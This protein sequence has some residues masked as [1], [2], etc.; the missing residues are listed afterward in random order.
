[1][2]FYFWSFWFFF[3]SF[4]H[5]PI[6]DSPVCARHF[7]GEVW[8]HNRRLLQKGKL[9]KHVCLSR[10]QTNFCTSVC[11]PRIQMQ[12]LYIG[13]NMHVLAWQCCIELQA[14]CIWAWLGAW[15][16]DT[17]RNKAA[18]RWTGERV[19][20]QLH[21]YLLPGWFMVTVVVV[22]SKD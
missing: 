5:L 14:L 7:C 21:L 15:L 2:F 17:H 11:C 6:S 12:K 20:S 9:R 13:S 10:S 3:S 4:V 19:S 8:P 16:S 22:Q 1:M 18:S